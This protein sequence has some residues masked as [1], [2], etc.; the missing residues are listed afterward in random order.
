MDRDA[1]CRCPTTGRSC[2]LPAVPA[3]LTR[4]N[5]SLWRQDHQTRARRSAAYCGRA[6]CAGA[7]P[8]SRPL[9]WE[10]RDCGQDGTSALRRL[11]APIAQ[12]RHGTGGDP[13]D[14]CSRWRWKGATTG[15][16]AGTCHAACPAPRKSDEPR[17]RSA[18]LAE[19]MHRDGRRMPE[20]DER[21]GGA[22]PVIGEHF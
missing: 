9:C 19:Q 20:D 15:G 1:S 8:G 16:D 11:A 13:R 6:A 2:L 5:R 3:A 12:R 10:R 21:L 4:G 7:S 14:L 22:D 17:E 18:C